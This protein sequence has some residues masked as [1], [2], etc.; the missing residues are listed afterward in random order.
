MGKLGSKD[1]DFNQ[2]LYPLAPEV[3]AALNTTMS[4]HRL[5]ELLK[6]RGITQTELARWLNR[7]KSAVTQLMQGKRQLKASEAALIAQNLG[8][9]VADLLGV[10]ERAAAQGVAESVLIPFQAAPTQVRGKGIIEKGG[11]F[12]IEESANFSSSAYA[13]EVADDGL[14]L[15]GVLPGDIVISDLSHAPREGQLVVAQAYAQGG[16]KTLVRKYAP[17]LLVPHSTNAAHAPLNI[18]DDDVRVVSPVLKLVR[19][20]A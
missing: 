15:S 14:N 13:L 19:V 16:A 12:F 2:A 1:W 4:Q 6:S 5:K 7:D 9:S 8:V 10:E 20:M 17:P 18:D 11:K 3:E